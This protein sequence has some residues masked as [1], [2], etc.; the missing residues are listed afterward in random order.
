TIDHADPDRVLARALLAAADEP[1]GT[2]TD[3]A[4][5]G[6]DQFDDAAAFAV[7]VV[8]EFHQGRDV[9]FERRDHADELVALAGQLLEAR[10]TARR[11]E[12]STT[13]I[14]VEVIE[15]V[16]ADRADAVGQRRGG[17]SRRLL[18]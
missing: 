4:V 5:Q 14:A 16:D 1:V 12:A 18:D 9:G 13:A 3:L 7:A 8:L 6:L 15:Q 11:R 17:G 10:G 2:G